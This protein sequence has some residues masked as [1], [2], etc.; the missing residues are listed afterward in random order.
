MRTLYIDCGMGAAG[1]MLS[2]ALLE[3][4]PD[5]EKFIDEL[6]ALG[7]PGAIYRAEPSEKCGIRGTRMVVTVNGTEE[8]SFDEHRHEH[9]HGHCHEHEHEHCHE[10]HHEHGH[11]HGHEH[12]HG[13]CH[14]HEHCHEHGH[15]HEHGH[16]HEH[17]HCGMH[18][19]CLEHEHSHEH[20]H[21]HAHSALS[22][23]EHIV[24]EH[25][26]LSA[27]VK[28]DVMAV[29]KLIAE[30]E[31]CAHGVPVTEIHFHEV[32]TMDA[33]ADVTAVC[34]LM[35]KLA[36]DEVVVS[37]IHVGSGKVRCAHGIL[38]VPAPA[39]AYILKDIPIYGGEIQGELCTPTGAAL[40]KHFADRFGSM[41][42]M[43][44]QAAGYGMGKKDFEAAN[45][46]RAILGETED[47]KKA[48]NAVE[49]AEGDAGAEAAAAG[50]A[51]AEPAAGAKGAAAGGAGA[52]SDGAEDMICEL[53]CNIDDMTG[54]AI[55]FAMER[56]FDAGA[57][58]VYTVPIGMKKSR[59][60][61]ML[62]AMCRVS[63]REKL[64]S[65]IFRH[66]S[67]IGIR[68]SLSR[69]YVLSRREETVQ[70]PY[71]PVL[72]KI[73]S[74]YGV[75][76][77]KYEYDDISRIAGENGLSMREVLSEIENRSND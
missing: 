51:A 50:E 37:P 6:N 45:C 27:K 5:K 1:D 31:S 74:G 19:H 14:E 15:E 47:T 75:Q 33:I 40:L 3:L 34:L 68:E 72:R 63:D 41:P 39:T 35:E 57:V 23:I 7:I 64:I 66:T 30:A 21:H 69:R 48:G 29:Y 59:P 44:L 61:V 67:T 18:G 17:E 32:G 28:A 36:A 24:C 71:G 16:V 42:V 73:S 8:E 38:P 70:T 20:E 9:E 10:H 65:A 26:P 53:S 60:A 43:R 55:G 12:E 77:K 46:V 62:C 56:L 52:G 58:D 54:E 11:A 2:A 22:D 13:H 4:I 25:L 49:E 76:R